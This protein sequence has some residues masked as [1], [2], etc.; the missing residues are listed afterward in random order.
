MRR[1]LLLLLLLPARAVIAAND[2]NATNSPPP[3]PAP[4]PTNPPSPPPA[5]TQKYLNI[6]VDQITTAVS[7]NF[8]ASSSTGTTES[9]VILTCTR[10]CVEFNSV[11]L[12]FCNERVQYTFCK[13]GGPSTFISTATDQD[14]VDI[15]ERATRN[16][17]LSLTRALAQ[18]GFEP[19]ATCRARLRR[20]F[21]YEFFN[22]CNSDG[23]QY[24][25]TCQAEC[26][27][28]KQTCGEANTAFLNCELEWEEQDFGGET[29]A[30]YFT[31]GSYDAN[32]TY[33]NSNATKGSY[34]RGKKPNGEYGTPI[35]GLKAGIC[36][37][38]VGASRA[39]LAIAVTLASLVA[40]S[41]G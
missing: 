17:F 6:P 16:A 37:G 36:T 28:I 5:P 18:R 22:Q 10:G 12:A 19:S 2:T 14:A 15:M 26:L 39:T 20:W 23:T 8:F 27:G 25:P 30:T 21:C 35:F 1:A 40:L 11:N 24:M 4:A 29:P 34:I 31:G 7:A 41:G 13:R 9:G 38:G 32:G 33:V 3:P